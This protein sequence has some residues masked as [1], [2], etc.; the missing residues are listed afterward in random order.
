MSEGETYQVPVI[1]KEQSIF[2]LSLVIQYFLSFQSIVCEYIYLIFFRQEEKR[3]AH[4]VA[5]KSV[6]TAVNTIDAQFWGVFWMK[7]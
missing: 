2:V 5:A 4:K 1:A 3:N 7:K 6:G